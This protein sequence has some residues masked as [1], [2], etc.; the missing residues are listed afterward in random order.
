M[1]F[2]KMIFH[3]QLKY[4]FLIETGIPVENKF[5]CFFFMDWNLLQEF[6]IFIVFEK[7]SCRSFTNVIFLK[8]NKLTWNNVILWENFSGY[9][10]IYSGT[11]FLFFLFNYLLP[12]KYHYLNVNIWHTEAKLASNSLSSGPLYD[13]R[14]S[15]KLCL[16][17]VQK[18]HHG[19]GILTR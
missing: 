14:I 10:Y 6:K 17:Q 16:Q 18:W 19:A 12:I 7:K 2:Y 8:E 5:S 11:L 15:I 13:I 3:S 9:T 4:F 1:N